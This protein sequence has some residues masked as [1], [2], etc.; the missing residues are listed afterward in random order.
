MG[1]LPTELSTEPFSPLLCVLALFSGF[2]A[3]DF[4]ASEW[5]F[6]EFMAVRSKFRAVAAIVSRRLQGSI[7]EKTPIVGDRS[8]DG[9]H[10][11]RALEVRGTDCLDYVLCCKSPLPSFHHSR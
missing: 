1:M 7:R 6:Q 10:A 5:S 8:G 9:F 11:Q 4:R 2:G 3:G